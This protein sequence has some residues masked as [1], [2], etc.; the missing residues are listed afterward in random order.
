MKSFNFVFLIQKIFHHV[1]LS[2]SFI[3]YLQYNK[4]HSISILVMLSASESEVISIECDYNL[5]RRR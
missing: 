5:P 3:L 4:A 1:A 2:T